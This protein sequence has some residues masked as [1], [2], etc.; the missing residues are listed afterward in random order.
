[1]SLNDK[2]QKL[3]DELEIEKEQIKRSTE[4]MSAELKRLLES[5]IKVFHQREKHRSAARCTSSAS[6]SESVSPSRIACSFR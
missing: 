4:E 6:T 3:M 2:K 5:E 1:M